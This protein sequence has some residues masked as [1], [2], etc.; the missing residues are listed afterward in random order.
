MKRNIHQSTIAILSAFIV[1]SDA[2]AQV[3]PAQV[4]PQLGTVQ[5]QDLDSARRLEE[6]RRGMRDYQNRQIKQEQKVKKQTKKRQKT[7]EKAKPSEYKTKGVYIE[8]IE[9]PESEILTKD[10]IADILSDYENTNLT[11]ADIKELVER[12]NELYLLIYRNKPLRIIG[13]R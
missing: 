10:E 3:S 11:M 4:I 5:Q 12:I 7:T 2:S 1:Y 9:V 6:E 8:K 13:L